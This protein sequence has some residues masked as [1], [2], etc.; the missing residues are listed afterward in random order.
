MKSIRLN[1]G[2]GIWVFILLA[3]LASGQAQSLQKERA[4][5]L[6]RE[7]KVVESLKNRKKNSIVY[8]Y[9][10]APDESRKEFWMKKPPLYFWPAAHF[11]GETF[12]SEANFEEAKFDDAAHFIGAK[13]DSGANF[14]RATFYYQADF[15]KAKFHS[16]A[17]FSKAEFNDPAY[18]TYARFHGGAY[19]EEAKFDDAAH[20]IA[21]TFH[22]GASFEGTEF[23]YEANFGARF[24]DE[25]NFEEAKFD[26]E[27]N[28]RQSTFNGVADFNGAKFDGVVD[29][30]LAEFNDSVYFVQ[31]RFGE[32]VNLTDTHFRQG[33]DFR[34]TFFDSAKTLYLENMTFPEGKLRFYWEHF[35]GKDSLRIK[36]EVP[37]PDS[38]KQEHYNRIAII[39]H[40]LRDNFLA[41]KNNV[42]ADE[43]M[44]ELGWQRKEILGEFW[45]KIYG[46]FFGYGFQPWR[47]LFFVVAPLI[48]LFAGI[49]YWFYYGMLIFINPN[50]S[51]QITTENPLGQKEK[52]LISFKNVKSIKIRFN[53]FSSLKGNINRLTRYWHAILF[54]AGVL[55]GIRFREKWAQACPDNI[56]G[57]KTFIYCVTFEWLLGIGLIVTFA[58]LAKG[59][60]FGFIRDLLGF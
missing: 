53:D 46:F 30:S 17:S 52:Y 41:Q 48:S 3:Q 31:S 19:F 37:P 55:L 57:R 22:H 12:D 10:G 21:T 4:W 40:G 58:L 15:I 39:Y 6:G 33:V 38:L 45:W 7:H 14:H 2:F 29:F 28:F 5:V 18:F 43:V 34:R 27:A 51:P 26:D 8:P 42:S 56:L 35:Q 36:L 11:I 44:Y 32:T 50:L 1:L 20:F 60:R 13:F 23:H 49:W 16:H 24:D 54:S 25:A 9:D 59:A 47:F